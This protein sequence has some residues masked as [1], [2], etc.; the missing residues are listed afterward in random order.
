MDTTQTHIQKLQEKCVYFEPISASSFYLSGEDVRRWCNGMFSNNIRALPINKGNRSG[1]CNPKGQVQGLLDSYCLDDE[2]F[3]IILDGLPPTDFSKRFGPY[4]MLDEI[5]RTEIESGLLSL[6]GPTAQKVLESLGYEFIEEHDVFTQEWGYILRKDRFGARRQT[7]GF[8]I[9][10]TNIA[11]LRSQLDN[12]GVTEISKENCETARIVSRT[13]RFPNDFGDRAF[14]H[15]LLINEECCSFNKGC[16]IGQ[17]II[18]RMDVKGLCNKRLQLYSSISPFLVGEDMYINEKK[19]GTVRSVCS[20]NDT[21]YALAMIRKK[22]WDMDIER[23]S[24]IAK[25]ITP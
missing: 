7:H 4:M 9:L 10:S 25:Y 12:L 13:A 16:Y 1:I 5:E 21:Y 3:L 8:D 22:A 6:Q 19:I 24:A 14:F 11:H 23:Q 18:N 20:V 17:E 15:E 2:R